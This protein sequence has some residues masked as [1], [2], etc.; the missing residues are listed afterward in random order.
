[1][2]QRLALPSAHFWSVWLDEIGLFGNAF[3]FQTA[4]GPVAIDPL[5]LDEAGHRRVS[6]LGRTATVYVT[7][8]EREETAREFAHRYGAALVREF[9][10][11]ERIAPGIEAVA[12]RHQR[13]AETWVLHVPE[14]QAVFTGDTLL[15]APAGALSMHDARAY[16][17]M[18][19]AALGLRRV[20]TLDPKIVMPA[21]GQPILDD[22]YANIYALLYAHAGMAVHRINVDELAFREFGDDED[23]KA[24]R[25]ECRDAEVGFTIGARG[26]GYRVTTLEPGKRFCPLHTHAQEEE[27]LFVL[28]GEPS[29]RTSTETIRCRQGDFVA[30]PVGETGTHQVLNESNA[31]ATF[32]LLARTEFPE[33]CRYPESN[34]LLVDLSVPVV[35]GVPSYMI[36][37]NP[38]LGYFHGEELS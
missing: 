28:D 5:P 35:N 19:R 33:I 24:P 3:L 11:G 18:R 27:L 14:L 38:Q 32:I 29:V 8:P 10:D 34:K 7:V 26:L 22:A 31:P 6:E 2:L 16:A 1:M 20:L 15:G 23:G 37:D 36:A 17:D 4:A 30:F 9:R 12:L 13:R 25:Y 21:F